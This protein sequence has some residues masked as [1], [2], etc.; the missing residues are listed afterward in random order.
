[1]DRG[2]LLEHLQLAE[3][4]IAERQQSIAHQRRLI[5]RLNAQ[6][7]PTTAAEAYLCGLEQSLALN[8]AGRDRVRRELEIAG[9]TSWPR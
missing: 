6:G 9:T 2:T 3:K 4:Q 5:A 1:M 7:Q 8:L